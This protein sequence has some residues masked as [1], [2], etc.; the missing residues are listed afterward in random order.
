MK[1]TNPRVSLCTLIQTHQFCPADNCHIVGE[2]DGNCCHVTC[3]CGIEFCYL[4][5]RALPGSVERAGGP[6]CSGCAMYLE[7]AELSHGL[8]LD[9][10]PYV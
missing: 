2:K 6:A 4:C 7:G 3:D 10:D 5:H 1:A 8:V 9:D